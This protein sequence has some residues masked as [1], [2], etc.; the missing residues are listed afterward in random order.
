MERRNRTNQPESCCSIVIPPAPL[1]DG[2]QERALRMFKALGDETRLAI[3]R[4][5]AAQEKPLCACDIV[6]R[7]DVSQP[8]IAHHLKVL[9]QAGL[10]NV[11]REGVWAYYAVNTEGLEGLQAVVEG[12]VPRHELVGIG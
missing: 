8:T 7:F 6:D 11:T 3:F 1:A 9:R 2:L 5:V 4:L 10:V 12:F